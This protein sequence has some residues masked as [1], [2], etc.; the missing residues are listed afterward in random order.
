MN[1]KKIYPAIIDKNVIGHLNETRGLC[2]TGSLCFYDKFLNKPSYIDNLIKKYFAGFENEF[3]MNGGKN[4][5]FIK[6]LEVYTL[7]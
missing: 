1:L 5:F 6:E 3:E 2:F 7:I 4:R